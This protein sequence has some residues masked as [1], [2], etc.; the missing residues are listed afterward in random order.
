MEVVNACGK[1]YNYGLATA[2]FILSIMA[3]E[4]MSYG[5]FSDGKQNFYVDMLLSMLVAHMNRLAGIKFF[6]IKLIYGVL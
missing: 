4:T 5:S 3:L 2:I 6:W 1:L